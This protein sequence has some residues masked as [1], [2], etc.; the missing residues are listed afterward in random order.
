MTAS[1]EVSSLSGGTF[2]TEHQADEFGIE[3]GE[4]PGIF[5]TGL[6]T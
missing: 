1:R 5:I 4:F 3:P 2:I 6:N